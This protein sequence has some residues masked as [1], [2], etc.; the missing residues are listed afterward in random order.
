MAQRFAIAA[1]VKHLGDISKHQIW[2]LLQQHEISPQRRRRWSIGTDPAFAPKAA[3]IVFEDCKTLK[4]KFQGSSGP[5][6]LGT[7]QEAPKNRRLTCNSR[8][9]GLVSTSNNTFTKNYSQP[10]FGV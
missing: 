1:R 7:T 8:W 5:T 6:L 9:Q 4:P 2:P 10:V 3:D